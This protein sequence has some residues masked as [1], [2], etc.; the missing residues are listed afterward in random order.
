[1]SARAYL[2]D[3]A[4]E[5]DTRTRVITFT[6]LR[7]VGIVFTPCFA[8]TPA[9]LFYVESVGRYQLTTAGWL[10][11]LGYSALTIFVAY[12]FFAPQNRRIVIDLSANRMKVR[13][14]YGLG[15]ALDEPLDNVKFTYEETAREVQ[16]NLSY[17]GKLRAI[18]GTRVLVLAHLANKGITI[19][20]ELARILP[21]ASAGQPPSLDRLDAATQENGRHAAL[22]TIG[23]MILM[24]IPGALFA[25]FYAR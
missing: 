22:K 5:V 13:G 7:W 21:A 18:S 10:I 12:M 19:V 24:V 3:R 17:T 23:M 14:A 11:A 9:S 6:P 1:M 20:Q 4:L 16:G 2:L 15:I 8:S 25:G